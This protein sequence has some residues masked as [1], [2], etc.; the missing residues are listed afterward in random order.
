MHFR[1]MSVECDGVFIHVGIGLLGY[2]LCPW[3]RANRTGK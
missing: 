2:R 3:D 1:K